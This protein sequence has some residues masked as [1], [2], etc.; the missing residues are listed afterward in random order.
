MIFQSFNL[1]PHLSAFRNITLALVKAQKRSNREAEAAAR[2]M[3]ARVGLE[4][5]ASSMP[6]ALSGGEQAEGCDS[7]STNN[8]P[9]GHAI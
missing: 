7:P 1:F 6:K 5:K 3:L 4:S 9:Q 8:E 2:E